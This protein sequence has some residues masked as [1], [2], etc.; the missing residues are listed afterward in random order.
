MWIPL[1]LTCPI[2]KHTNSLS[3]N[4]VEF[5]IEKHK[6]KK[7]K[8]KKRKAKTRPENNAKHEM[9]WVEKLNTRFEKQKISLENERRK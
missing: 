2:K 6:V 4:C 9:G 8:K 1:T 3:L 5:L 7:K